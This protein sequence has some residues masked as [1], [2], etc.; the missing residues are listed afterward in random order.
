MAEGLGEIPLGSGAKG[1]GMETWGWKA[2]DG[3]V[4]GLLYEPGNWGDLLKHTWMLHTL[5]ALRETGGGAVRCTDPFAGAPEYPLGLAVRA[6]FQ[7]VSDTRLMTAL[8]PYLSRGVWPGSAML[9]A[10]ACAGTSPRAVPP[11]RVFD[12]DDARR[13]ALAATGRFTPLSL[14]CGYDALDPTGPCADLHTGSPLRASG[15]SEDHPPAGAAYH[16]GGNATPPPVKP[17]QPTAGDPGANPTPTR[18]AASPSPALS[19][20][21]GCGT[22]FLLLDPYD[23]LA[24]WGGVLPRILAAAVGVT[25]LLYVYNRS[26]RGGEAFRRY[27]AFRR[28]VEA[29]GRPCCVGRV[30]SDGFLP[31]THHEM[32]LFPSDAFAAS[33]S[34]APL[35][36]KLHTRAH[37]LADVI[38]AQATFQTL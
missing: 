38:A 7:L 26:G 5:D 31:T 4:G 30:P 18:D 25:V 20:D 2:K 19:P 21:G 15:A 14:Q 12:Q 6:R 10:D 3:A 32:I 9:L 33:G 24:D 27:R 35:Q 11:V 23:V 16:R 37:A 22:P 34:Y 13:A 36:A 1:I 29:G 28:A 17:V 8:D